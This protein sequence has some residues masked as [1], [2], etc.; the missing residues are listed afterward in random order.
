M[1]DESNLTKP[2][3]CPQ[4][5]FHDYKKYHRLVLCARKDWATCSNYLLALLF[6]CYCFIPYYKTPKYLSFSV[7]SETLLRT[8]YQYL[9]ILVGFDTLTY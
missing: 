5:R 4:E 6:T 2:P 7:Y 8:I 3:V 9:L 1:C